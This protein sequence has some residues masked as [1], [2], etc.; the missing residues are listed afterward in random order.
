MFYIFEQYIICE[1]SNQRR[2]ADGPL[3]VIRIEGQPDTLNVVCGHWHLHH[4]LTERTDREARFLID[5]PTMNKYLPTYL[6]TFG[7]AIRIREPLELKRRIQEKAYCIA[8]H[9]ENDPN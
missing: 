8:K 1:Q 4:Y 2:E 9:Y 6:L 3:T 7:T 5:V